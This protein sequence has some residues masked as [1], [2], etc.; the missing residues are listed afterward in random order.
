MS[1]RNLVIPGLVERF[2]TLP[3]VHVHVGAP[4]SVHSFPTIYFYLIRTVVVASGQVRGAK[5]IVL[6]QAVVRWQDNTQAEYEFG[7]LHDSILPLFSA[8][9]RDVNGH[10]YATLGGR[11][12]QTTIIDIRSDGSDGYPVIADTPMRGGVFE[13]EALVKP[14]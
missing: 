7:A 13:L 2:Q 1:Y 8:N 3:G 10:S 5:H 6:A 9:T 12:N 4:T 14:L 11:V